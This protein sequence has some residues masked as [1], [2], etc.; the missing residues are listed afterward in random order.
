[1]S[2]PFV[3]VTHALPEEWISSIKNECETLIGPENG[4]GLS[5]EL[6]MELARA[7]GLFT[8]LTDPVNQ[9]IL[10]KAPNLKVVSNMAVGV[11]NI[12]L[13]ACT[14][15]KIP[16][17]H[18]PGVLTEGTADLSMAILLALARRIPEAS[19]DARKGKWTTWSPTGWLGGDL[20]GAT[21]GIIGM[22]KIGQS[23]AKR[24]HGFGMRVIYVSRTSKPEIEKA[25]GAKMVPFDHLLKTSDY[26]SLHVPLTQETVKM[27]GRHEINKMKK[28][29]YLINVSRG[30]VVNTDDLVNALKKNTIAGAALDVT[31]PEPLPPAH[32]L[33]QLP[34][35]LITPHIGSATYNTRRDMTKLACINLLTGLKG[36][37]LLHCVNPEVYS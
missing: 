33:Y 5:P 10:E 17:G 2:K 18:T 34:N 29:A 23:V 35:C 21:I 32:P 8:L 25:I 4:E 26:I 6:E 28:S 1:M 14:S 15:R 11:D 27:I 13:A 7:E 16:V 31:D 19:R 22:G 20:A 12:D 36:E 3:I 9:A 37:R 24:A 30:P